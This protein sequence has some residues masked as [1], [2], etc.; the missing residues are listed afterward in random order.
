MFGGTEPHRHHHLNVTGGTHK[1]QYN[2]SLS[3][4]YDVGQM[5]A[6]GFKRNSIRFKLNHK[7]TDRLSIK[8]EGRFDDR[9]ITGASTSNQVT[10]FTRLRRILQY[11]P[12]FGIQGPDK[13]LLTSPFDP[14]LQEIAGRI[15]AN[16]LIS[17]KARQND[18]Y[19]RVFGANTKI[20]YDIMKHLSY[21]FEGGYSYRNSR[22]DQ[23]NHKYSVVAIRNGSQ[24]GS[25]RSRDRIRWIYTNLL[26]YKRSIKKKHQIGILLGQEQL[27]RN[28]FN[29]QTGSN[30]FPDVNHGL[31]DLS[32]G[33]LPDVPS[34][35]KASVKRLSYFGRIKYN[36]NQEFFLTGTF[37]ADGSTKFGS[38]KKYGLFPSGAI[39]WQLNK[40]K[41][42]KNLNVFNSLK[43]RFSYGEAGNNNIPN[44]QSLAI[45][46][47]SYYPLN[48]S[49]VTSA[50][51]N[52]LANPDLQWETTISRDLGINME[53]LKGRVGLDLDLYKNTTKNLLLNANVPYTS[54][55]GSI[56]KNVGELQ[57]KGIELT[58]NTTN[59]RGNRNFSWNSNFNLSFNRNKVLALNGQENHFFRAS[60][61]SRNKFNDY[62]VKVG[63]P[64]G[65]MFGYVTD[66][67][68]K[69][70]DFNYDP[71]TKS[72]NIKKGV[73]YDHNNA[74]Q[75]GYWKFKDI[76]DDGVINTDDRTII[77]N[78]NP[79]FYGGFNNTFKYKI[80]DLSIFMNFVVGDDIY[81]ANKLYY[82]IMGG[83]ARNQLSIV[84]N[85][86]ITINNRGQLITDPNKLATINKGKTIPSWVGS[87]N[88]AAPQLHSWA[89]ENGSYLK[90]RNIN[91]GYSIPQ[92][93]LNKIN[94]Q[95]LRVYASL[96][97]IYTFTNY[98]GYDP[99]VGTR[100][101]GLTPNI[102]WGAYPK[103]KS[104]VFG[105]DISF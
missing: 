27:F 35:N 104:I 6:S 97:N 19:A 100:G 86:W 64:I 87:G 12:T 94:I 101:D 21:T 22:R 51:Q 39:A 32:L 60:K 11:R 78:A 25:I 46:G 48:N 73:P 84:K 69:V 26:R 31:N 47:S 59:I 80:F 3:R 28:N 29:L 37:R 14:V 52:N 42:I 45:I 18:R 23:F 75:P 99:N 40:E 16:P 65:L 8:L 4:D 56:F 62:I 72:Y 96:N 38:G 92:V 70:D 66:G 13:E 90:I 61:W 20:N 34:S 63:K 5:I 15:A 85:R 102:D 76:N 95:K 91:L 2:I 9:K 10:S 103:S 41:F 68:Y 43:I 88:Q 36:Y 71:N 53:F 30:G 49:R 77:G 67:L 7:E 98:S 93:L 55:F 57:N 74:P 24:S 81:N 79:K 54:G 1:T 33:T 83:V 50:V 17:A 82:T 89:I 44:Y 105:L 58:I